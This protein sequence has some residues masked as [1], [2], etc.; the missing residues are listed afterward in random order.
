MDAYSYQCGVIDCFNEMVRAG[1]K[2]LALAH[3]C[4]SARQRAQF[5]PFCRQICD[6]YGTD[7]YLED[8]FLITDLFPASANRGKY[9]ILFFRDSKVLQ[10]YLLL[11]TNKAA[12]QRAGEYRGE[13]RLD[14]ALQLG[15]LL[16]YPKESCLRLIREN[17]DR[18][19]I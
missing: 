16:G 12:L 4:E 1:L 15:K 11:K 19:D 6:Q 13:A 9:N 7:Y 17:C 14:I 8:D 2:P 3:P 18:E 5:L 10:A